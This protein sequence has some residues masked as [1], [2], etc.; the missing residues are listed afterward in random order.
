M[1]QLAREVT[2]ARIILIGL[3]NLRR[4]DLATRRELQQELV[5]L[6]LGVW[7]TNSLKT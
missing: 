1:P 6:Q 7:T 4:S 3:D 2:V 5:V